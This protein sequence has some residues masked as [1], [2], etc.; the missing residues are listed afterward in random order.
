MPRLVTR[1]HR[2][3]RQCSLAPVRAAL[4]IHGMRGTVIVEV[5]ISRR[6]PWV[7]YA[8]RL[9]FVDGPASMCLSARPWAWA[10]LRGRA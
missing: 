2:T 9:L 4:T 6:Y 3:Q 5:P 8:H 10:L 7:L 1:A